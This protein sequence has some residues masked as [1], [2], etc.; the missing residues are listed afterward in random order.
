MAENAS[1]C[2][3]SRQLKPQ[4]PVPFECETRALYLHVKARCVMKGHHLSWVI[5]SFDLPSEGYRLLEALM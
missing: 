2:F 4:N 1:T 3:S 5:Q